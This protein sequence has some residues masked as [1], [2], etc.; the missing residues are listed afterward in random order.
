MNS[1]VSSIGQDRNDLSYDLHA[2]VDVSFAV[3]EFDLNGRIIRVNERFLAMTGYDESEVVGQH[4]SMFL[5][6]EVVNGPDYDLCW[7]ELRA[8]KSK[9]VVLPCV[10]KQGDLIW[11]EETYGPIRDCKGAVSA[12]M[13]LGVDVT[14]RHEKLIDLQ[15]KVDAI[16]H[17][18]A[19][20]EFDVKGNILTANHHFLSIM[21]YELAEIVGLHHSMF[22]EPDYA[23][24]AD[25]RAFWRSLAN[26]KY[27]ARQFRRVGKDG[28]EVWFEATYNP[29]FAPDGTVRKIVKFAVDIT[30]EVHSLGDLKTTLDSS[31]IDI[32][33]SLCKF[34]QNYE[35]VAKA[36]RLAQVHLEASSMIAG[37]L[38]SCVEES[39]QRMT[40]L[41][42]VADH[43]F[44]TVIEGDVAAVAMENA[45]DAV[46]AGARDTPELK[47]RIDNLDECVSE[48]VRILTALRLDM[49]AMLNRVAVVSVAV[50]KQGDV[51]S[52]VTSEMHGVQTSLATSQGLLSGLQMVS[53]EMAVAVG[54]TREASV[55]LAR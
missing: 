24:S 37:R 8:G 18:H 46:R 31:F 20:V 40:E 51:I 54:R 43:V 28:D 16:E 29:V 48:N 26:G 9:R 19:V 22:V 17:S 50:E 33:R 38:V 12:I 30:G 6:A 36:C 34:D 47:A 25:Y 55:V 23:Q 52:Q 32:D 39:A 1:V 13:R 41:Q 10:T 3:A 15:G 27:S 53:E 11:V 4:H 35:R 42:S 2:A 5:P 49:K 7:I 14:E 44:D 45:L 21:G